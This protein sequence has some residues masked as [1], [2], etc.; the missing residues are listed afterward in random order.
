MTGE[1]GHW[2]ALIAQIVMAITVMAMTITIAPALAATRL[3][4]RLIQGGLVI[5]T[6]M[7][8]STVTLDGRAVRVGA[9]GL[10][11]FGFNRDAA[12]AALAITA[13]DGTVDRRQLIVEARRY[14]IQRIDG[15]LPKTVSPP[16]EILARIR[17]EGAQIK[18]ARMQDTPV[19][20]FKTG[21]EWPAWGR[22]SGV[23]G[24]QR[25]LNGKPRRPH[26]GVDIAARTGTP[27]VATAGGI[28]R[29]A[30]SGMFFTGKT[31]AIDHG[32]GL[33]SIYAHMS[34]VS[35]KNGQRVAKGVPIGEVGATGRV[36][37]PH[38]HWGVSWFKTRLDPALLVGPMRPAEPQR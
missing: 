38:L 23:Y 19:P 5:G 20:Y 32:H 30:H 15:L 25:I 31:V 3:E 22:I 11:L 29:I 1:V 7:P 33:V 8:G 17:R 13:P 2:R 10:F 12:A 24:S 6:T 27:I 9:D 26:L 21:F 37:G 4:G 16:L 36:T 18:A 34:K 14:D 28:V 35:A